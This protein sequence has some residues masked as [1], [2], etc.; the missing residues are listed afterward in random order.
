MKKA[1]KVI[2]KI[3]LVLLIIVA[4]IIGYVKWFM[5]SVGKPEDIKVELTPERIK[6]GEYLANSVAVCM[7]CHST[8]DWSGYAGPLTEGTNGKGGERFGTEMGF[9]GEF[10][11]KNITPHNLK[12]WTDGEIFRV[13]T[14]GVNKKG[15][16]MFPVMPYLNYGKM[17]RED[18]YDIIAYIRSLPEIKSETKE[19]EADF[20]MSIIMNTIPKKAAFVKKPNPA[21]SVA[22]GQY[23]ITMASCGDCHTQFDK[24]EFIKG[25]EYGG[26]REFNFPGGVVKSANITPHAT[27][28]GTWTRE[29]FIKTFK[30]YQ[31]TS[32]KS[33]KIDIMKQFNTPMPWMMYSRMTESDLSSIYQF[34]KTVKPIDGVQP[35][36]TPHAK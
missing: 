1:L 12:D 14:T 27:G 13:I 21:D 36:F 24:G 32:Y 15:K 26:G 7:D 3:V 5:P 4:G 34:L 31:D 18:I 16:A 20:P 33:P 9:P 22:Y 11:S 10:Y 35:K 28:I 29:R 17:D 23:L 6:H 19:S 8:R 25:T 30:Q 2:F